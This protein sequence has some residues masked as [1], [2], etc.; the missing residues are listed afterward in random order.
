MMVPA[1]TMSL[2]RAEQRLFDYIQSRT[3]EVRYWRERVLE[4]DRQPVTRETLSRQLADDLSSYFEERSRH[5]VELRQEAGEAPRRVSLRNLAEYL[6]NTWPPP[7][8]KRGASQR[9]STENLP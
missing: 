3:E 7:R 6:L 2:N 5:E 4:I 8:P 1:C 9:G